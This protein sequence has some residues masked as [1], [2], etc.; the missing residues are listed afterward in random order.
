MN[1]PRTHAMRCTLR[2]RAKTRVRGGGGCGFPRK[3]RTRLGGGGRSAC[4]ISK[5]NARET[6]T[7][8]RLSASTPIS[9]CTRS[10]HM[11][12]CRFGESNRSVNRSVDGTPAAG[13]S[14]VA[15]PSRVSSRA[16][17]KNNA[18]DR[19]VGRPVGDR[20]V[21]SKMRTSPAPTA[22]ATTA[23]RAQAGRRRAR[24]RAPAR[25]PRCSCDRDR[26]SNRR[27]R[28]RRGARRGARAKSYRDAGRHPLQDLVGRRVHA[29][30]VLLE[31]LVD[32][33]EETRTP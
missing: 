1:R 14:P 11:R 22:T 24:A 7:R 23:V 20:D 13:R 26:D 32:L 19:S 8:T 2:S 31:K 29:D 6:A 25:G 5:K 30:S 16:T 9:R 27:R 33:F 15:R 17:E 10:G 3:T 21:G 12:T 18:R 4:V 28:A